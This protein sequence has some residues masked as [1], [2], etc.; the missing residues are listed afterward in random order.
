MHA[1]S[2]VRLG[3]SEIS[4]NMN[5]GGMPAMGGPGMGLPPM[6]PGS[7]G[8]VKTTSQTTSRKLLHRRAVH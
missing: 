3:T 1:V 5:F 7:M 6:N 8:Q 4:M 2:L